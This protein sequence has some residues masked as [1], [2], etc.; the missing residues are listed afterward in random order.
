MIGYILILAAI[1][2]AP[3]IAFF[4]ISRRVLNMLEEA[5]KS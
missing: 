5:N 4:Y 3:V 1:Q 2:A